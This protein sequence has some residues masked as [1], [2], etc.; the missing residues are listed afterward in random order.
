MNF[1]G[2]LVVSGD[3]PL[4]ITGNFMGDAVKGRDLSLHNER[5][6]AGI[7]MHRAIDTF[8]D[9][10]PLTLQGRERL[11]AHTGKYAGVALDLFYDHVLADQWRAVSEEPL[12]R[13]VQRMYALLQAHRELMPERT[14][15]ML[16]HMVHGDWLGSYVRIQGIG[17]ALAGL[18]GRVPGGERLLGA[19]TV[20][21]DH[22]DAYRMEGL[23]F[24]SDLRKHLAS[25][26]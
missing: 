23:A 19:E 15:V 8:T 4:V 21:K 2:H 6:Q 7:R 26:G 13:F 5:V 16:A 24:L 17:R 1:L 11:R 3:D 14:R 12:Q 9:T 22:I 10:H 18:A 25:H 20:L